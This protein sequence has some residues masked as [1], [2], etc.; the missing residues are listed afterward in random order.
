MTKP[1]DK[2]LRMQFVL[3][4][5]SVTILLIP[6][7]TFFFSWYTSFDML[8]AQEMELQ[9]MVARSNLQVLAFSLKYAD[10]Y[11]DSLMGLKDM[12]AFLS[13]SGSPSMVCITGACMV[14]D[15]V[16]GPIRSI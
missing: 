3:T 13:S 4:L 7:L 16:S 11:A 10:S 6:L 15:I 2:V 5:F 9:S 1:H 8:V 14:K 12:Q